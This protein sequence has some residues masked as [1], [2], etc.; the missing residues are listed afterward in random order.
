MERLLLFM[1]AARHSAAA[2]GPARVQ[3][4]VQAPTTGAGVGAADA[5]LAAA[6]HEM[7]KDN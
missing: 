3:A 6:K 5:G 1:Q 4:Q 2:V 7:G